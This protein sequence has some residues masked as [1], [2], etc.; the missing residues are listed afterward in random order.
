MLVS[1]K[2]QNKNR[3]VRKCPHVG[4]C[5]PCR[6][7]SESHRLSKW[8][9]ASHQEAG[10]SWVLGKR[11]SINDWSLTRTS[12]SHLACVSYLSLQEQSQERRK[13]FWESQVKHLV[14][15]LSITCIF[16]TAYMFVCM[17]SLSISSLLCFTAIRCFSF[18]CSCLFCVIW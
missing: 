17:S 14:L 6:S 4:S 13:T 10:S 12:R 16:D 3:Y 2:L 18:M 1:T 5:K 9:I 8:I 7:L 11:L 15:E